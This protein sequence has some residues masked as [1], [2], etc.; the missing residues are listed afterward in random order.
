MDLRRLAVG[1]TVEHWDD[2]DID[3]EG[4][5]TSRYWKSYCGTRLFVSPD[6]YQAILQKPWFWKLEFFV[7]KSEDET[8]RQEIQIKSA[9]TIEEISPNLAIYRKEL[10]EEHPE[11]IA[12][13]WR[14]TIIK[15]PGVSKQKKIRK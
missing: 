11:R 4:M 9:I 6:H 15:A 5:P 14:L 3:S 2:K 12:T 7:K 10:L 1:L 8:V 13:G